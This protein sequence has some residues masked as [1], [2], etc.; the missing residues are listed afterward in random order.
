MAGDLLNPVL[1]TKWTVRLPINATYSFYAIS[2]KPFDLTITYGLN[3]WTYN[4]VDGR[5]YISITSSS[6]GNQLD[7][8]VYWRQ[9]V[10]S[11]QQNVPTKYV[12]GNISA[13]TIESA[14][15]NLGVTGNTTFLGLV[16]NIQYSCLSSVQTLVLEDDTC[17]FSIDR[18]PNG[19][20]GINPYR[21]DKA[22]MVILTNTRSDGSFYEYSARDYSYRGALSYYFDIP[23]DGLYVAWDFLVEIWGDRTIVSYNKYEVVFDDATNGFYRSLIN[24]NTDV[25]TVDTSWEVISSYEQFSNSYV[26]D[27]RAY[28][29]N[30]TANGEKLLWDL[31]N[32]IKSS[33]PC[34]STGG[35]TKCGSDLWTKYVFVLSMIQSACFAI[36]IGKYSD[37]Q[38]FLEKIPKNCSPYIS[39]FKC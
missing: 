1:D 22:Q 4:P 35:N 8:Q 24:N 19:Y 32:G 31:N 28:Y 27:T 15:V 34:S 16:P 3:D 39:A 17:E 30:Q 10:S 21:G 29:F 33:C 20:G 7:N 12:S 6:I 13:G 36:K 9:F 14:T 5:I 11:D 26:Y 37:A 38:C 18:K 23:R 2:L 25:V